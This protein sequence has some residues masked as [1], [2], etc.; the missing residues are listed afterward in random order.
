M[1]MVTG[2]PPWWHPCPRAEPALGEAEKY[3]IPVGGLLSK[4]TKEILS[5]RRGSMRGIPPITRRSESQGDASAVLGE[6]SF[7]ATGN[8]GMGKKHLPL[9]AT[10]GRSLV[11][12][13]LRLQSK[14]VVQ[15]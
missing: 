9:K 8:I 11:C 10:G 12:V 2:S 14:I 7:P 3:L 4:G 1:V 15:F 5:R 6:S 13:A